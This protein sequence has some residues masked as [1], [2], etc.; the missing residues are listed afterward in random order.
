MLNYA[1]GVVGIFL[2]Y[3]EGVGDSDALLS[4]AEGVADTDVLLSYAE[5]FAD[6]DVLLSFDEVLQTVTDF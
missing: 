6:S 2:S 1:E 3:A 5:G 4:Y